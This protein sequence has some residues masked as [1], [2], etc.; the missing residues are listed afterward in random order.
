MSRWKTLLGLMVV[1][2][3]FGLVLVLGLIRSNKAQVRHGSAADA[4]PEPT[5][6][7]QAQLVWQQGFGVGYSLGRQSAVQGNDPPKDWLLHNTGLIHAQKAH[8]MFDQDKFA[9][10][11]KAG[12]QSGYNEFW[13]SR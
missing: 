11:F 8:V 9:D 3:V 12:F 6:A 2:L 13:K 4:T 7:H 10:G 1:L 5:M